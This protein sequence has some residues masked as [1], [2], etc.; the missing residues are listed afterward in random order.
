[1]RNIT[2]G[3]CHIVLLC[4]FAVTLPVTWVVG[5]VIIPDPSLES[6]IR[7]NL[8][9]GPTDPITKTALAGMTYLFGGGLGIVDLT[10]LEYFTSLTD[11]DLSGNQI[12][13][14]MP[15]QGLTSLTGLALNYNRIS[16]LTPLQELT[17]VA[18]QFSSL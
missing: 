9:L 2:P 5:D 1:M 14:L 16:D 6:A 10:G 4:V 12:S 7:D 15:L 3:L 11:L 13:D 8:G 17:S 18:G